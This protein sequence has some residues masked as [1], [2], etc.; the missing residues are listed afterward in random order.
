MA[1]SNGTCGFKKEKDPK[2]IL[3][4]CRFNRSCTDYTRDHRFGFYHDTFDGDHENRMKFLIKSNRY[5]LS[6]KMSSKDSLYL[7]EQFDADLRNESR[8]SM[9]HELYHNF[10]I[11]S[12]LYIIDNDIEKKDLFTIKQAFYRFEEDEAITGIYYLNIAF[13]QW[14][15]NLETLDELYAYFD[16][17]IKAGVI[18]AYY[19]IHFSNLLKMIKYHRVVLDDVDLLDEEKLKEIYSEFMLGKTYKKKGEIKRVFDIEYKIMAYQLKLF[20]ERVAYTISNSGLVFII[21]E[22]EKK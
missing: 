5:I 19:D 17:L 2:P 10:L 7:W 22:V 9:K 4:K 14:L 15:F 21:Q 11:F 3:P 13:M 1:N 6:K 8:T 18:D 12:Y 16:R 20:P